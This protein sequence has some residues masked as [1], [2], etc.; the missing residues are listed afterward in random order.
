MPLEDRFG[1]ALSTKNGAAAMDY[2]AGVDLLLSADAG[3]EALLDRAL[4]ADPD[5]ALG[6]I[7]KARLCQVQARMAEAKEAAGTARALAG[8]VS[9]REARHI[10]VIA[11]AVDGS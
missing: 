2:V 1:L 5:F 9:P 11:R 8:R 4:A 10:E 3:A 6:H 7:A